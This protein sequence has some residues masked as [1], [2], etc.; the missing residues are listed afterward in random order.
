[1]FPFLH[2]FPMPLSHP[3]CT[4]LLNLGALKAIVGAAFPSK[5][6]WALGVRGDPQ[7][8]PLS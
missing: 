5:M 3:L 8:T 6:L 2:F 4:C 1:M 7:E